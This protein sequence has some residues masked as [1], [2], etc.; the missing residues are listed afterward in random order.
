MI[1]Q[2]L[3]QRRIKRITTDLSQIEQWLSQSNA[4]LKLAKELINRDP[5]WALTIA[6]Q[7]L[8]RAGRSLMFSAG[9]LPRSSGTHKTVVEYTQNAIGKDFLPLVR[10]FERLRRK[11]HDFF[12]NVMIGISLDEATK[13]VKDAKLLTKIITGQ[14]K[15]RHRQLR[16]FR[17]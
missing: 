9:Y 7:A 8:L 2:L 1:E 6:Y 5:H 13:A 14:I 4:D 12:Y 17:Q 16:L 15:K 3:R 10:S 11:R